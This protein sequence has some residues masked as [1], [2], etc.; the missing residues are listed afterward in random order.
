[1]VRPLRVEYEGAYYHV[2]NRGQGR[3]EIYHGDRYY[4]YFLWCL[5]QAHK[6]F[7]LE[8]NTRTVIVKSSKEYL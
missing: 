1:M 6:R 3:Q 7:A 8:E 5:E 4:E 2:M